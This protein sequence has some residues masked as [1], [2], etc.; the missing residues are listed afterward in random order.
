[1]EDKKNFLEIE[2]VEVANTVDLSVYSFV[3][4]K[5]N[6]FVFKLRSRK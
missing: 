2:D 6:F 1:M 4:L 3:G 5:H